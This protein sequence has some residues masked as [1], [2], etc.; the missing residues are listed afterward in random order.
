MSVNGAE[1][2]VD[3]AIWRDKRGEAKWFITAGV[4]TRREIAIMSELLIIMEEQRDRRKEDVSN[5]GQNTV[6]GYTCRVLIQY[7]DTLTKYFV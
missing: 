2:G 7:P 1:D 6:S 4:L 5:A 3:Y